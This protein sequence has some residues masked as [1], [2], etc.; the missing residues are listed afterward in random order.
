[1]VAHTGTSAV[2]RP[3]DQSVPYSI[4]TESSTA[5]AISAP[6]WSLAS[7]GAAI[8]MEYRGT[9]LWHHK[10][11]SILSRAPP[12]PKARASPEFSSHPPSPIPSPRSRPSRSS[13]QLCQDA[14][15]RLNAHAYTEQDQDDDQIINQR[16]HL[17][18]DDPVRQAEVRRLIL[19]RGLSPAEAQR[20]F[21][22]ESVD[23]QNRLQQSGTPL[24]TP[25]QTKD[26]ENTTKSYGLDPRKPYIVDNSNPEHKFTET[27]FRSWLGEVTG[28][29]N[30]QE[31]VE[32]HN[33]GQ[34]ALGGATAIIT[35]VPGADVAILGKL[36]QRT[37]RSEVRVEFV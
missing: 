19:E 16:R 17:P 4:H 1:M 27:D 23:A 13:E 21:W 29:N 26:L 30:L 7:T 15:D 22:Q 35:L 20:A 14:R 28:L 24:L 12:S 37:G 3:R 9:Q 33:W 34:A 6:P 36:S 8:F 32:D 5:L 25:A 10:N 18:V 11:P 31:G 2:W